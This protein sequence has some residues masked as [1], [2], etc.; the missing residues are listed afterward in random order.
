[1]MT[2]LTQFFAKYPE[3]GVFLALGIGYWVGSFKFKGF[4]LGGATGSLLAGIG[5]G[6][7]FHV[8]VASTAK[9]LVFLLF[10]FGI[11]Y[12]VGPKFFKAMK[13]DGWR[14]GVLG[15]FVPV[16]GLIVA[17]AV[18][19]FLHLDP[20]FSGGLLS[21]ALTESPT[22]GTASEAI[23][24]LNVSDE[25]KQKWV[26]HVA[27]ADALCYLFGAFGV[28]W[29]CGTIAPKL[30]GIDVKEEA[31]KL[32]AEYG[33]K[34][35]ES[36]VTSAWRPYEIRSYRLAEG[37]KAAGKSIGE[38]EGLIPDARL[39]VERVRRG[40][41][42]I[43]S[44]PD[45]V[46]QAGDIVAVGGKREVLMQIIDPQL[47]VNDR[48]LIDL[49]VATFDVFVRGKDVV[50]HTVEDLSKIDVVRGVF[51]RGLTRGG[52]EIPVGTKTVIERGDVLRLVGPQ[53]ALDRVVKLAGEVIRPSDTTDFVAVCLAIFI[54]ALSGALLAV[55][56][57]GTKIALG[58]SVGTLLAGVVTGY[59]RTRR[60]LFGRVPDGAVSFMQSFGLAAFVTMVGIGAGPE[61]VTAIKEAGV[62]LLFGGMVVTMV[63]LFAGL[64]FGRHVLKMNPLLLIGGLAGAQTFLPGI[65]AV[66]ERSGSGIVVLGYSGAVPIAHVLLTTWGTVIVLFMSW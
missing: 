49:P 22:I 61:C 3:L 31:Q 10:V 18:A 38:I 15:A 40:T 57:A 11:G 56:V 1:M 30:L 44:S 34:R 50:G 63:P 52:Q 54:G 45:F 7:C 53:R 29:M 64:Y 19:K 13:G 28:I 55:P 65:A 39:F 8:P 51:L 32:E 9:S 36:G 33:I 16:V 47:E 48:E 23:H 43:E 35:N 59:I 14:F 60:P 12:S 25:L 41:E 37:G 5:V 27:V 62:G 20:G 66:Q 17:I 4:S 26:T 24:A 6:Y 42:I 58:T 2:F 21:G 46:L